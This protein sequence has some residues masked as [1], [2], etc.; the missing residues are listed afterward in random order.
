[1]Q[2]HNGGQVK[3]ARPL[4]GTSPDRSRSLGTAQDPDRP[5]SADAVA[6]HTQLVEAQWNRLR[7]L[8]RMNETAAGEVL[9]AADGLNPAIQE[10]PLA[11]LR[12]WTGLSPEHFAAYQKPDD[13][14]R[15]RRLVHYVRP[16]DRL[17]D[18]GCGFGYVPGILLR[19]VR[20]AD[21]LGIDKGPH[22]IEA[23]GNMV[24]ENG[25]SD[26]PHRF[27]VRDILEVNPTLL[28]EFRPTLVITCEVF[29]HLKDP[30]AALAAL[31]TGLDPD[32]A[33]LFTVPLAG[34]LEHVRGHV[35]FFDVDRLRSLLHSAGLAAYFVEPLYNKWAF[36]LCGRPGRTAIISRAAAVCAR[37]RVAPIAAAMPFDAR[38][39]PTQAAAPSAVTSRAT[40]PTD[41]V[42][43]TP[44]AMPTPTP[45]GL[46]LSEVRFGDAR[47]HRS[48]WVHRSQRIDVESLERGLRC[49]VVGSA[50]SSGGQY[51]GVK[52]SARQP[53][54]L[55]VELS[56]IAPENVVSVHVVGYGARAL[57]PSLNW[58]WKRRPGAPL[59]GDRHT[60]T[61]IAGRDSEH[62][63]QVPVEVNDAVE[64]VHVF[65]RIAPGAEAGFA[66]HRAA[67]GAVAESL[68]F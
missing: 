64:S 19:D 20:P 57:D 58:V 2:E 3:T 33:L 65:I 68:V 8:E 21:Y 27:E 42:A 26:R 54:A 55:Q 18:A 1:M 28:A 63:R 24:K 34:R 9:R 52:F 7:A 6:L 49:L 50:D 60:H 35:S 16:T 36:V 15:I 45:E 31:S 56:L 12:P 29:E 4:P 53:G 43:R 40:R 46:R 59:T 30:P 14:A 62:F 61:L 38:I 5:H 32:A 67:T 22:R 37:S 48:H 39:A 44:S 66:L 13:Q 41:G 11:P 51:G 23:A 47:A 25:L 10:P 17:L